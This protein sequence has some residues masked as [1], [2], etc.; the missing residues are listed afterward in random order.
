MAPGKQRLGHE[1][2]PKSVERILNAAKIRDDWRKKRKR[3]DDVGDV[4]DGTRKR[5]KV[6]E[7]DGSELSRHAAVIER[8]KIPVIRP[9]ETLLQFNQCVTLAVSS[10]TT[11]PSR[12]RRV[13]AHMRPLVKSAMQTSSAVSRKIQ[14]IEQ[15]AERE[16]KKSKPSL[17][18]PEPQANRSSLPDDHEDHPKDF[19]KT[20]SSVPRRLND[21]VTAPPILKRSPRGVKAERKRTGILS[22]A[23]QAM[24]EAE[25]EKAILRY[26]KMKESKRDTHKDGERAQASGDG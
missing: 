4:H 8:Q 7:E 9:G 17:K 26:R 11:C 16:K 21:V 20:S 14:K 2:V 1:T 10:L 24:M 22:M 25:R 18:L 15:E 23:Q 6:R 5:N 13:E 12:Y 3:E 19:L